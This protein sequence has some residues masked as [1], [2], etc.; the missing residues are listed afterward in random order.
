LAFTERFDHVSIGVREV[1]RATFLFRDVLGGDFVGA[2]EVPD[3]GFRFVQYRYPNRMKI[4][5]M[6]PIG[7]AGFLTKFLDHRGEGVHHLAF[8]VSDIDA[9]LADLRSRG[10]DPVHVVVQGPW[11][12]AFIHPRQAHG[13][14]IQLLE[15]PSTDA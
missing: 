5:L 9:R 2:I 13:V 15:M 14:L 12:E 1:E 11:K 10:I 4:E 8:K 3:E 6:E 7:R